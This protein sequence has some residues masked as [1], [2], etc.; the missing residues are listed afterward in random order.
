MVFERTR[1]CDV[2][3]LLELY[4]LS[5]GTAGQVRISSLL[6][7]GRGGSAIL[8]GDPHLGGRLSPAQLVN[9]EHIF[10]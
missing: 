5:P 6:D 3:G 8:H 10:N 9:R 1:P 2:A 4:V 7:A